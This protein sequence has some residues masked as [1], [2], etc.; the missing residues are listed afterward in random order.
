MEANLRAPEGSGH[1]V[2]HIAIPNCHLL[3][4][5]RRDPDQTFREIEGMPTILFVES[6][7]SPRLTLDIARQNVG[8]GVIYRPGVGQPEAGVI[9]SVNDTHVFVRYGADRGSKATRPSDLELEHRG[10]NDEQQ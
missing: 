4:D 8:R 10:E 9:T 6:A 2:R 3:Q 1:D 5:C 7:P